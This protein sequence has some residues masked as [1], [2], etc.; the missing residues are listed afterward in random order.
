MAQEQFYGVSKIEPVTP[1]AN[2]TTA[3]LTLHWKSIIKWDSVQA[4]ANSLAG[5]GWVTC[6]FERYI[7][8]DEKITIKLPYRINFP[9]TDQGLNAIKFDNTQHKG[10]CFEITLKDQQN[11]AD[12]L[13]RNED[14]LL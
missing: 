12:G 11:D 9:R 13:D 8:L 2:Y 10:F 6:P 4:V 1:D 3:K 5:Q 7:E 14:G